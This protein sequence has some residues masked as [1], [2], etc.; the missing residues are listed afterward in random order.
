VNTSC[1]TLLSRFYIITIICIA[2]ATVSDNG[3]HNAEAYY[4]LLRPREGRSTAIIKPVSQKP[5]L[6]TMV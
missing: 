4:K 2:A 1:R 5:I 6:T 3:V